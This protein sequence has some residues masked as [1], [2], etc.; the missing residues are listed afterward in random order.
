[1]AQRFAALIHA[2]ELWVAQRFA[3]LIHATELLGGAAAYRCGYLAHNFL[4]TFDI[5]LQVSFWLKI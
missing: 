3:A 4:H 5:F 1:V 2:T